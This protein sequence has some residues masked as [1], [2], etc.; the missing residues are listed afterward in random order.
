ML[1]KKDL[2]NLESAFVGEV[3]LLSDGRMVQKV[4]SNDI[5]DCVGCIF[6]Y[7]STCN[8]CDENIIFKSL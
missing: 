5:N 1:N 2:S 7:E 3:I 4:E 8:G 6:D